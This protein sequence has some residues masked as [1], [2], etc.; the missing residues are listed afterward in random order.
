MY[1]RLIHSIDS[2]RSMKAMKSTVTI[3]SSV[4]GLKLLGSAKIFTCFLIISIILPL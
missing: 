2:L 4:L 3:E 1:N